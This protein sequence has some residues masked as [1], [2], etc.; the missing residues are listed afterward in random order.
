MNPGFLPLLSWLRKLLWDFTYLC[1]NLTSLGNFVFNG[2][3]DK[4]NNSG[5]LLRLELD[6]KG[7]RQW[8][9]YVAEIDHDGIPHPAPQKKGYCYERGKNKETNCDTGP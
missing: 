8:K 6:K 7:V 1:W 5:W 9:T 2:F 3:S 4:D